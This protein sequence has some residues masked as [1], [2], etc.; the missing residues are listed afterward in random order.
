VGR[1][2]ESLSIAVSSA[3][4]FDFLSKVRV[5]GEELRAILVGKIAEIRRRKESI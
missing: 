1:I 4:D 3:D 2:L 5:E